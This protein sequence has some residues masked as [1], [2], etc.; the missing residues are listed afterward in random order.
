M[1]SREFFFSKYLI[2][3]KIEKSLQPTFLNKLSIWAWGNNKKTNYT[4]HRFIAQTLSFLMIYIYPLSNEKLAPKSSKVNLLPCNFDCYS[5]H[6]YDVIN[7]KCNALQTSTKNFIC[8]DHSAQ[9]QQP[10]EWVD[11]TEIFVAFFFQ[12]KKEDPKIFNYL[13][14]G[15]GTSG[16]L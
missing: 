5:L 14:K 13:E 10:F 3:K 4:G 11:L 12:N 8:R 16:F 15:N 6:A 7:W 1:K 2:W 9:N